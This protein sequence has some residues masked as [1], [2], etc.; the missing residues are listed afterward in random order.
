MSLIQTLPYTDENN[1]QRFTPTDFDWSDAGKVKLALVANPG[2]TFNQAYSSDTG[3]TYDSGKT[4]FSGGQVR[5]KIQTNVSPVANGILGVNYNAAGVFDANWN[6][7][8]GLTAT[9]IGSPTVAGGKLDCSI[10]APSTVEGAGYNY[11]TEAIETIRVKYTPDYN[12]SS[13]ANLNILGSWDGASNLDRA[14]LMHSAAGTLRARVYD[15]TGVEIQPLATFQVAAWNAVQGQEYIFELVMNS[16]AGTITLYIDGVIHGAALTPG[17]WSRGGVSSLVRIGAFSPYNTDAFFDDLAVYDADV[18]PVG[19]YTVPDGSYLGDKID[20]PQFTSPTSLQAFT[21]FATTETSGPRYVLNG[22]Y[23][24]GAAWVVSNNSWAQS[25]PAADVAANIATLP[26]SDTLDISIITN[27]GLNQMS[28]DDTTVTYTG[29][30]YPTSTTWVLNAS[31]VL[32]DGLIDLSATFTAAGSDDVQFILNIN[33]TDYWWSGA[34]WVTS[35][36]TYA[37]SNDVATILAQ[38]ATIPLSGGKNLAIKA[39]LY[40]ATGA[41]TPELDEVVLTYDFAF[42]CYD[43]TNCIVYGCVKSVAE[44]AVAATVR[45]YSPKPFIHNNNWITIDEEVT[46]D[47]SGRWDMSLVETESI[48]AAA[49][50]GIFFDITYTGDDGSE[51]TDTIKGKVIPAQ[52]TVRFEDLADIA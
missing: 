15:N 2:Q 23:W 42:D 39:V 34:A 51:K 14:Y 30:A 4:E 7:D 50:K 3:F 24:S 47:S 19:S 27:D 33:G 26:A 20:L 22:R 40:S 46:T 16:T 36:G 6:T 1:Y 10:A 41:T 48:G 17:A 25:S 35:N 31:S 11:D 9:L 8:A 45:A 38:K 52:S 12:N 44:T 18:A 28:V 32:T 29:Q 21:A 49:E 13:V 37:E 43:L 5:Q